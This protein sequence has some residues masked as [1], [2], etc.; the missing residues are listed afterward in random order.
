MPEPSPPACRPLRSM[1]LPELSV[2]VLKLQVPAEVVKVPREPGLRVEP[3]GDT[4]EFAAT[5]TV[6]VAVADPP[7]PE[8]VIE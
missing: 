8:Q 3:S 4:E 1:I 2:A 5:V 7:L 6:A